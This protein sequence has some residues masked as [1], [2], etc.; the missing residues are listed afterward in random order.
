[1]VK[2]EVPYNL[3]P[4]FV[5]KFRERPELLGFIDCFYAAAWKDDCVNT[6]QGPIFKDYYPKTYEEYVERL[7]DL[8][9]LGIPIS[10]LAQRGATLKMIEKYIALGIRSFTINDDKLAVKIQQKHPDVS[11]TRS[12]TRVLTLEDIQDGDYSM[13]DRIVLFYWFNRH[14]DSLG[15][16]PKKYSYVVIPNVGCYYQCPWHDEHWFLNVNSLDEYYK[17]EEEICSKCQAI[18]TK[19]NQKMS[20]IQPEDIEF[21]E[22]YVAAFKLIDRVDHTDLIIDNL[23]AYVTRFRGCPKGR[24]YYNIGENS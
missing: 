21:F 10:I 3:K 14:L 23:N 9:T 16:L 24:D 4:D 20:F 19:D 18:T 13:Y 5:E 8:M 1:M 6:R 2:F 7:K 17:G 12:V 15:S 22:P 11:L